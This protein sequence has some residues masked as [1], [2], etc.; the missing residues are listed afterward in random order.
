MWNKRSFKLDA[1]SVSDIEK[2]IKIINPKKATPSGNILPKI[3][4]T[5]NTLEELFNESSNCEFP[6]KLNLA[7]I[8]PVFKKK[9]L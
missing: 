8:A 6:N 2:E 1:I 3:L 7:D 5:V 9:T 4:M